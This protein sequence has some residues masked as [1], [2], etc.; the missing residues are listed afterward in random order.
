MKRLLLVA[1]ALCVA[2]VADSGFAATKKKAA[3]PACPTGGYTKQSC[4]NA[5]N[6]LTDQA[7]DLV[8]CLKM[9]TA[10]YQGGTG[11]G[12]GKGAEYNKKKQGCINLAKNIGSRIATTA[13]ALSADDDDGGADDSALNAVNAVARWR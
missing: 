11:N 8:A 4:V 6:A 3:A 7:D 13:S 2:V 5:L 9:L 12:V 10:E 1:A